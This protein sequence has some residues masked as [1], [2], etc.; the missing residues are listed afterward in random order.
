MP[1]GT[2]AGAELQL[3]GVGSQPAGTAV[4]V[5]SAPAPLRENTPAEPA[6]TSFFEDD[7]PEQMAQAPVRASL[8]RV[9]SMADDA[10]LEDLL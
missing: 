5:P 3:P 9:M 10:L 6:P 2:P 8:Q 7:A 4:P 1:S